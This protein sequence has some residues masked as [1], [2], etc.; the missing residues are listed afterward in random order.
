MLSGKVKQFLNLLRIR[1]YYKNGLIFVGLFFSI[2]LFNFALYPLVFLGLVVLC[3]VS[4]IN[5]IINDILDIEKD[6]KHPEKL[7]KKPLAS[8]E[9]SVLIAICVVILLAAL[10]TV[11]ILLFIQNFF[12]VLMAILLLVTGQAYNH[13][14]KDLAFT[15]LVVLSLGYLW[16]ALAGVVLISV[17]VSPW[18]L[19]AIF[20]IAMFL[21][22]AKRKGDLELLGEETAK[23]HKKTYEQYNLNLLNQFQTII[24]TS[25]FITWT[26]YLIIKFNFFTDELFYFRDYIVFL[27][28]PILL[29][30][31][32][33]Y[34][35]LSSEKP[36]IAR[37]A[38]RLFLDK[39]ILIAG[40][41]L[42]G[43]LIFAFYYEII[44]NTLGSIFLL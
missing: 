7:K 10:A 33:R 20:E 36:E 8:G 19:L 5:Y 41:L 15:D 34:L 35:Y 39:G 17:I 21:S 32:M 29:Y 25:I 3:C 44:Y 12:F 24:T 43:I 38:E 6:K 1:Q 30:I 26:L 42:F 40:A 14:F 22:I 16:R 28:V 23:E 31:L 11:I 27:T 4:S 37:S 9:I 18:L 13:I 2:N